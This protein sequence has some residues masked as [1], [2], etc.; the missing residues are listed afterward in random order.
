MLIGMKGLIKI[1]KISDLS[2]AQC[3]TIEVSYKDSI[4][5][6]LVVCYAPD[7]IAAYLNQ[8][9]HTGVNLNWQQDQCYDYS[10][11]YLACSVHG[12]LFQPSDGLC[13]YGPCIGQSLVSVKIIMEGDSIFI[14]SNS[15][16]KNQ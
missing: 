13:I 7:K 10:Q 3:R 1:L 16:E 6:L 4:L 14:D 2:V 15:I 5:E 8:C 12:A 11:Q 9:P